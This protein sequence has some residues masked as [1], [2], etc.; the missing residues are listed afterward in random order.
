MTLCPQVWYR[1]SQE[2]IKHYFEK[3]IRSCREKAGVEKDGN[4]KLEDVCGM[5]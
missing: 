1:L 4:G 3:M 2:G 5:A